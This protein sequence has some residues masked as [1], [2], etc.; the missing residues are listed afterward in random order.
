MSYG[1]KWYPRLLLQHVQGARS[2]ND[3]YTYQEVQ[4]SSFCQSRV[5]HGLFADDH[6]FEA[7]LEKGCTFLMPRKLRNMFAT[8]L[9][10]GS[11]QMLYHYGLILR[12][13]YLIN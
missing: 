8:I 9:I 7:V 1:K 2:W 4:Y 13:I 5:G 10:Y 6:E 3:L 11:H 12:N